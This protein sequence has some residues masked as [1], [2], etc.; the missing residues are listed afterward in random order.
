M[1]GYEEFFKFAAKVGSLEGYLYQRERPEPLDNWVDNIEKMY[2]ALPDEIKAEIKGECSIV[3]TKI[4]NNGEKV[5]TD[6]IK[7]RL[8]RM[9]SNLKV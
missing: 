7:V 1:S 3:L 5:L 8:N 6:E 4:L 2:Q 9:L